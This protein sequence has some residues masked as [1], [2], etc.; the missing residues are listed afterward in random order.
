MVLTHGRGFVGE[1]S[2]LLYRPLWSRVLV[3]HGAD[4]ASLAT[5][6][7]SGKLFVVAPLVGFGE[8]RCRK[9]LPVCDSIK[10]DLDAASTSET[11]NRN[12]NNKKCQGRGFRNRLHRKI[13]DD[14]R[15]KVRTIVRV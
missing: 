9:N 15:P 6:V 12:T 8:K 3:C 7:R 4:S 2:G 11:D 10:H 13:V 5:R 1:S 14:F